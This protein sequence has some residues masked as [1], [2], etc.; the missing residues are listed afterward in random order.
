ME[1]K[2]IDFLESAGYYNIKF[3]PN[4][5]LCGLKRFAFTTGLVVGMDNYSY[6]GRYCY[7]IHADA[8]KAINEWNGVGDPSGEWVKYKG[9][10]G[11]RTNDYKET[12]T[13]IK[14]KKPKTLYEFYT[15]SVNNRNDN[16]CKECVAKY[17]KL[18]YERIKQERERFF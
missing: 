17:K 4:L 5:G 10:G 15:S 9:E 18:R 6:K 7:P 1:K 3:I 13:C 11:E 2:L 8:V 12:K 16:S 14:C